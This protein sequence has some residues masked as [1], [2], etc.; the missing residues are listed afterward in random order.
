MESI[1]PPTSGYFPVVS[2]EL[3]RDS[4]SPYGG[5]EPL[6]SVSYAETPSS[7]GQLSHQETYLRAGHY[8]VV[9]TRPGELVHHQVRSAW[10]GSGQEGNL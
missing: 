7:V 10:H 1:R 6:P 3:G 8:T 2:A 9:T 4:D 5:Q